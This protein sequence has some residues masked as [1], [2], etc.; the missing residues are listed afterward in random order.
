MEYRLLII[1]LAMGAFAWFSRVS[2]KKG[3]PKTRRMSALSHGIF[4]LLA[5]ASITLI[6]SMSFFETREKFLAVAGQVIPVG[7]LASALPAGL[8]LGAL[9]FAL[10]WKSGGKAGKRRDVLH[11]DLEWADTVFSSAVM[12]S[13][14]MLFVIQAFKIPSASMENTLLIGDHLFVNKFIYG[15][16]V[17]FTGAARSCRYGSRST[18]IYWSSNSP[19]TSNRR[20]IAA[21]RNTART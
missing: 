9:G 2:Q 14:L 19:R 13:L 21:S 18:G 16:R 7:E 20:F 3:G 12:A 11:E 1:G 6:L 5:G 15:L 17:P 8:V 10:A 4:F